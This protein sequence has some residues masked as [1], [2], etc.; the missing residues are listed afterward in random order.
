MKTDR[1]AT[2]LL[3]L[4]SHTSRA[5]ACT[6]GTGQYEFTTSKGV[7]KVK[8]CEWVRRASTI[9]RCKHTGAVE[10]CPKTCGN[11]CQD[12]PD[13]F[14]LR[15]NGR[16]RTCEWVGRKA[17]HVAKRCRKPP[18]SLLCGETCNICAPGSPTPVPVPGSPT[19][20]PT[21]LPTPLPTP[22]PTKAPVLDDGM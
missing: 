7:K 3:I 8:G 4:L 12:S 21:P 10:A 11:C 6:D 2:A 9:W 16:Q 1:I 14:N 15:W 18:A 13:P 5:F 17:I 19:P 20:A 22:T